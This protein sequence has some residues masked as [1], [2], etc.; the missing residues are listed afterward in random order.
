MGVAWILLFARRFG[1]NVV[2]L[3]G[4]AHHHNLQSLWLGCLV[5]SVLVLRQFRHCV[6]IVRSTDCC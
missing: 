1:L 6:H 3:A 4:K 2:L 5:T